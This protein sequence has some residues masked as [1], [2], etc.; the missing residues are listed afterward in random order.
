MNKRVKQYKLQLNNL[1][2][3][4]AELQPSQISQTFSNEL[5][6][7]AYLV[8]IS[9]YL[10][11]RNF[12][13][14]L[15]YPGGYEHTTFTTAQQQLNKELL[16]NK[17]KL[18]PHLS[19]YDAAVFNNGNNK[20]HI[21]YHGASSNPSFLDEDK[22]DILSVIKGNH[23]Q[24]NSFKRAEN[25]YLKTLEKYPNHKIELL[26]TSLGGAKAIHV[27]E[28]FNVK[29]TTFNPFLSHLHIPKVVGNA[30]Q[31][32]HRVLT[33]WATAGALKIPSKSNRKIFHYFEN[34]NPYNLSK[35]PY[36]Y[37]TSPHNLKQFFQLPIN[38]KVNKVNLLKST[39]NTI[40]TG[41]DVLMFGNALNDARNMSLNNIESDEF[42]NQISEDL[43][44]LGLLGLNFDI[45]K[46][47]LHDDAPLEARMLADYI[48]NKGP[49][50]MTNFGRNVERALSNK[51]SNIDENTIKNSKN[52]ILINYGT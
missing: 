22:A 1:F 39:F 19:N 28:N 7:K 12:Q 33:D 50:R 34:K 21:A 48:S 30:P 45:D 47:Y 40:G 3:Q 9:S 18:D 13:P 43:N 4:L 36:Q 51:Y 27:G 14:D 32:I 17:F 11:S 15:N 16:N 10:G 46:N 25:V 6:D 49:Q 52:N 26:G 2:Q 20:I 37:I 35:Q 29:S 38:G 42:N 41:L 5:R 23:S 24:R 44:P 31:N 8:G